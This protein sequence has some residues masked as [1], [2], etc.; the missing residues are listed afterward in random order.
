MRPSKPRSVRTLRGG[1]GRCAGNLPERGCKTSRVSLF[2]MTN[3]KGRSDSDFD[4]YSRN[5]CIASSSPSHRSTQIN[6]HD[7][8]YTKTSLFP[9]LSPREIRSNV[10]PN[11]PSN[12]T[13]SSSHES[14]SIFVQMRPISPKNCNT[15]NRSHSEN[16]P[17]SRRC[18]VRSRSCFWHS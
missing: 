17:F 11:S 9:L 18:C 8:M 4:R 3:N 14:T 5:A 13:S 2:E 7:N 10:R 16:S 15:H 1:S 12:S 6:K